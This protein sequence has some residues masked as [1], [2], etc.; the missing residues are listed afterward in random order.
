MTVVCPH[1]WHATK[2]PSTTFSMWWSSTCIA[3]IAASGDARRSLTEAAPSTGSRT[4]TGAASKRMRWGCAV[5]APAA[6]PRSTAGAHSLCAVAASTRRARVPFGRGAARHALAGGH[7]TDAM[8]SGHTDAA[9][10]HAYARWGC[11][12]A[13]LAP[14]SHRATRHTLA[15]GHTAGG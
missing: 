11:M 14:F 7:A 4:C 10:S 15:G 8:R 13:R 12:P 3:S 9:R 6:E 2:A 5:A 1:A